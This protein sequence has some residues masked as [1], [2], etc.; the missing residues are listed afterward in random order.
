MKVKIYEAD[1]Q[2]LVKYSNIYKVKTSEIEGY[3]VKFYE[4]FMERED[5]EFFADDLEQAVAYSLEKDFPVA[6]MT[7]IIDS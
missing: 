4:D 7:E 1:I 2:S 5:L 3:K 6:V